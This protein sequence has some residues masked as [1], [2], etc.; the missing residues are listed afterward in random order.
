VT[1][2]FTKESI[3]RGPWVTYRKKHLTQ[4][5]RID[6]PFG[7]ETREGR[8]HC[9]DGYLAVDAHGYPYPIATDEFEMIYEE[10]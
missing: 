9:P 4:A 5:M 2:F 8:V 1:H 10:V 6:G 7:V 3:P